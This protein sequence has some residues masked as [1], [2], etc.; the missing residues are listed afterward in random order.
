MRNPIDRREALR[1]LGAA[2]GSLAAL[3]PVRAEEGPPHPLGLPDAYEWTRPGRPVTAA[4]MG[5]GGRGRTYASYAAQRPEEL[6][7]VGVAEPIPHR[8]QSMAAAHGI[9]AERRWDT[10]ER[11]FEGP[12]FC[13]AI[14]VTTP[15]HLHHGPAVAALERGYDLLLE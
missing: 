9:P 11:A 8:N 13:D 1:A 4:I 12:R 10:W 2:A 6:K 14:I 15:D 7:I 3:P 5:A